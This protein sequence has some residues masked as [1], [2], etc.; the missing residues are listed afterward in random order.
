[1]GLNCGMSTIKY[2]LFVFNLLCSLCGIALVAIGG[3]SMA[4]ISELP[5][6]SEE[7]N[8]KA[9]AIMF[10]VL[11]SIIF[12]IGFFGCCGAIRKNHCMISTYAFFLF[13]LIVAQIVIAALVF[14]YVGDVR[15]AFI[16]G[17]GK[18]FD[19]RDNPANRQLI[20]TIQANLQCCGKTSAFDWIGNMPQSCCRTGTAPLCAPYITGCKASLADFIDNSGDILAW[21]SLGVAA[22]ELIGLIAACCLSNAIRNESRRYA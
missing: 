1:M 18:L 19:E 12:I 9:P 17:F 21:V 2:L 4:K 6:L 5:D 8:I 11:G 13:M 20:D 14:V 22:V 15:E 10:I 16:K 3:V 7:H